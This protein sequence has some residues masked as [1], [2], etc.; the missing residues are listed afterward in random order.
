VKKRRVLREG[1][2]A[3]YKEREIYKRFIYNRKRFSRNKE[4]HFE[5]G[6]AVKQRHPL[7]LRRSTTP[8]NVILGREEA[9]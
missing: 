3:R 6:I 8:Q 1:G 9:I 2:I 4:C 7:G 5:D